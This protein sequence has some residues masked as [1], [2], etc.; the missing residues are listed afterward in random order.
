MKN[1]Y[2]AKLAGAECCR[3]H[4]R[5]NYNDRSKFSILWITLENNVVQKYCYSEVRIPGTCNE[6]GISWATDQTTTALQIAYQL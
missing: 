3:I 5:A 6:E 2:G 1:I 4:L